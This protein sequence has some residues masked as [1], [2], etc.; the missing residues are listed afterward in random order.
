MTDNARDV[1][2]RNISPVEWDSP[3]KWRPVP[4]DVFLERRSALLDRADAI[5]TALHEAGY[6]V[7]PKAAIQFVMDECSYPDNKYW[8]MIDG[9][10]LYRHMRHMLNGDTP[11]GIGSNL[12]GGGGE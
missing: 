2:A 1:I 10:W 3:A 9:E 12:E 7:T 4:D 8:N 5:I 11:E 6:V